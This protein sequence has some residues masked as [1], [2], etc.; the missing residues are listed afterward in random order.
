MCATTNSVNAPEGISVA[1]SVPWNHKA[2]I[3]LLY[4]FPNSLNVTELLRIIQSDG[5]SSYYI[6]LAD[7]C[8]QFRPNVRKDGVIRIRHILI[9]TT[10]F[11]IPLLVV[12]SCA[13]YKFLFHFLH[14]KIPQNPIRIITRTS[15]RTHSFVCINIAWNIN[16]FVWFCLHKKQPFLSGAEKIV[17][18]G[19]WRME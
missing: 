19:N 6:L 4:P 12:K 8:C 10:Y 2:T 9:Q 16:H 15:Y 5:G 17:I 7:F 1:K 18:Y 11:G 14:T 13:R 3:R